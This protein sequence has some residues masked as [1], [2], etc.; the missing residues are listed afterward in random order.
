MIDRIVELEDGPASR[1]S[2]GLPDNLRVPVR[3]TEVVPHGRTDVL[4]PHPLLQYMHRDELRGPGAVGPP[5]I[6][7]R[8]L[9]PILETAIPC[10]PSLD[11]L[12]VTQKVVNDL[13]RSGTA[14]WHRPMIDPRQA[15][16]AQEYVRTS[17][18]LPLELSN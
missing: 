7:N 18:G 5:Q 12:E 8:A 16:E 13:G 17:V 10:C 15:I 2:R 3:H 9:P 14:V 6:V 4:V 1:R 11:H